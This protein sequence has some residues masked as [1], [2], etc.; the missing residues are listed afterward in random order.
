M[1][2]HPIF[3]S[4]FDC[5]TDEKHSY[6]YVMQRIWENGLQKNNWAT[7][8]SLIRDDSEHSC[9]TSLSENDEADNV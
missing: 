6:R 5:L 9:S 3:E 7:I 4:D 1:G 2:T 8:R